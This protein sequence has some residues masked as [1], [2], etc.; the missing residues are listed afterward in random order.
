MARMDDAPSRPEADLPLER[1][2][3]RRQ[4]ALAFL[5]CGVVLSAALVWLPQWMAFPQDTVGRLAFALRA[6]LFFLIWLLV[7]VGWVS[8]IRRYSAQDS[9]GS[10]FGPPSRRLAIPMAFLQNTLEQTFIAVVGFL[11]LA[12]VEGDAPLAYV[13]ASIPLFA[14]GRVT[15]ARGYPRGAGGRAFGMVTTAVPTL[16]AYVWVLYDIGSKIMSAH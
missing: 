3:I 14:I 11:A 9:P 1:S 10:A 8:T 4:A 2:R 12:T 5:V 16:G 15:F 6:D 7:G 13:C